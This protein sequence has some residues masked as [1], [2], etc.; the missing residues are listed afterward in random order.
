MKNIISD[1]VVLDMVIVERSELHK[2]HVS[3][4]PQKSNE[5]FGWAESIT[6][7]LVVRKIK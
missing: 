7:K 2:Y 6:P 3:S 4:K 5:K 1:P